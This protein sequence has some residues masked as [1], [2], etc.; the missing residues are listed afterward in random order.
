MTYPVLRPYKVT[1]RDLDTKYGN[2]VTDENRRFDRLKSTATKLRQRIIEVRPLPDD[3]RE[4]ER[5]RDMIYS[6]NPITTP[7]KIRYPKSAQH[8]ASHR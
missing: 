1:E 5:E 3:Q 7:N 2:A 4:R 6:T 8:G